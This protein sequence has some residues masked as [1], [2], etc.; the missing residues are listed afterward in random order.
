MQG[1]ESKRLVGGG[2]R[3]EEVEWGTKEKRCT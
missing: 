2:E 1:L 3:R